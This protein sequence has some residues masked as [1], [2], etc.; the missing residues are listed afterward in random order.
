M[1][2]TN[3]VMSLLL[4]SVGLAACG[5]D[6]DDAGSTGAPSGD[7]A[8]ATIE[9]PDDGGLTIPEAL[10][11]SAE[12]PLAVQGFL[13]D[14]GSTVRL[15]QVALESYP[16]QC[17]GESVEVEGVDVESL[18]GATTEGD[19]TWVEYTTLTGD[20]ESGVLIVDDTI[21]G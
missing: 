4:L 8:S 11:S 19:V 12:G 17:G 15:C 1:K 2:I 7:E 16:P 18:E 5:A 3:R 20:L 10:E 21:Q 6:T 13:I 9:A 14:D